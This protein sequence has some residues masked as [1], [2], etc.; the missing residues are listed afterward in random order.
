[1]AQPALRRQIRQLEEEIGVTLFERDHRSV[2]LTSAGRAFLDEARA[3]LAHSEQAVRTAQDTAHPA[4]GTLN[5][6]YVWGLFHSVVPR[7]VEAFRRTLPDVAVNLFDLTATQQAEALVQG[8]LDAGFI[9]F[10]QEADAAGLA[11]RKVGSCAFMA[12][13]PVT[14][15]AARRRVVELRSLARD[16]FFTISENTYPSAARI[17]AQACAEAGFKPRIVQ[18]AERGFT[19]LG[20]VA[21]NCGV[22]LVP[23][24]LEALPHPGVVFRPLA[25]PPRGE[26]FVAWKGKRVLPVRDAFLANLP[27]VP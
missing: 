5:L 21:G 23:E 6:G 24:S 22:A 25:Q 26:L 20:L 3:V 12:A 17:A 1:V 10:A 4:Q 8:R 11:R 18:A 13:L 16:M 9:G 14:H 2:H 15:P 19:L 7:A 27:Q